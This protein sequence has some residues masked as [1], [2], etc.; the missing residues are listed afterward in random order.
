MSNLPLFDV[1]KVPKRFSLCLNMNG[2]NI[3]IFS[4]N[5][6]SARVHRSCK[7]PSLAVFAQRR[8]VDDLCDINCVRH[9]LVADWHGRDDPFYVMS[10]QIIYGRC[11]CCVEVNCNKLLLI[12]DDTWRIGHIVFVYITGDIG[13]NHR[14]LCILY[15]A[16]IWT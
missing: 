16:I 12:R 13:D 10:Q 2:Y 1:L 11:L 5:P 15:R 7:S 3:N 14:S 6:G 8:T 4:A 9:N